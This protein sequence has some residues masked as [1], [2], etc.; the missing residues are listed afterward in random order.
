MWFCFS[1]LM[2]HKN[3]AAVLVSTA[4]VQNFS[5]C[6]MKMSGQVEFSFGGYTLLRYLWTY[7][8]NC[9]ARGCNNSEC[10]INGE[11]ARMIHHDKEHEII[12]LLIPHYSISLQQ[13]TGKRLQEQ[14]FQKPIF[15]QYIF[16]F[17]KNEQ[18][19]YIYIEENISYCTNFLFRIW[20]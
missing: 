20:I 1:Y 5:W 13:L 6:P 11:G 3:S 16:E 2:I 19:V 15:V 17:W 12:F 14:Y 18:K 7:A 4:C 10:W 9:F 8:I